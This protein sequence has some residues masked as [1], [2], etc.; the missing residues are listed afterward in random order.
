[1]EGNFLSE[2]KV[3]F[4]SNALKKDFARE[5]YNFTSAQ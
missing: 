4:Y 5:S 1:M 3:N 2:L